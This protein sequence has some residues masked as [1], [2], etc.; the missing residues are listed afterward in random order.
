[1][2]KNVSKKNPLFVIVLISFTTSISAQN[3]SIKDRW[4]MNLGYS[5]YSQLGA[6]DIK[7]IIPTFQAGVNYGILKFIEIGLYTGYGSINTIS[8]KIPDGYFSYTRANTVFYGINSNFHLLP[9]IIKSEKFRFDV[10]LSGKLGGFYRFSD[11]NML[12][13]R[14]HNWDYGV[15]V[16]LAFYPGK[17]WGFFGE[18]G[19]GNNTSHRVGLSFKF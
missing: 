6:G 9:F 16:C 5:G 4:N 11:E 13:A 8:E 10:Y 12:P 14:G 3:Y 19:L 15:Y 17:H 7:E 18:Y 1:M 2:N